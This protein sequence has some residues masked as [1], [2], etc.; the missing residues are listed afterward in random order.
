[1]NRYKLIILSVA[2]GCMIVTAQATSFA[3]QPSAQA[4]GKPPAKGERE[5]K[6][7]P[8]YG[9]KVSKDGTADKPPTY[10]QMENAYRIEYATGAPKE[11][12]EDYERKRQE[13]AE[14]LQAYHKNLVAAHGKDFRLEGVYA[15]IQRTLSQKKV[16]IPKGQLLQTMAQQPSFDWRVWGVV[17]PIR[18]QSGCGSCWAFATVAAFESSYRIQLSKSQYTLRIANPD[19][20]KKLIP[21]E[22][23]VV[24]FSEQALLDCAGKRQVCG[25]G[26]IG[27]AFDR[28]VRKGIPF[29]RTNRNVDY[30]GEKNE[31]SPTERTGYRGIAWDYVHHP[32]NKIPPVEE[33]KQALIEHGP[34]AVMVYEDEAFRQHGRDKRDDVFIGS[35]MTDDSTNHAIVLVG[36]DNA[37][38]AW[39][40]RNSRGRNWGSTCGFGKERGYHWVGWGANNIGINAAWIE[41]PI[42]I[43]DPAAIP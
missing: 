3:W 6:L 16:A 12:K 17:G 35:Q 39:L 24:N 30:Q 42:E 36:W 10:Q 15:R 28:I 41:A 40:V 9:T 26:N 18:N 13:A 20:T 8:H 11:N 29:E 32:P 43:K 34:L 31:C 33:L 19:G 37:K 14:A 1:M 38:Q 27:I 25:T 2:L 7:P 22:Q 4:P 21:P 23:V 5:K